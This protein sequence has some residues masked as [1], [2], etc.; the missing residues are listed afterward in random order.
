[1]QNHHMVMIIEDNSRVRAEYRDLL[2]G[3]GFSVVEACDGAEGLIWLLGETAD[4]IV[5]DL[6]VPVVDGRSFLEYRLRDVKISDIPVVV[7]S[8]RPDDAGLSRTLLRLGADR[9]LHQP[10]SREDFLGTVRGLLAKSRTPVVPP[11]AKVWPGARKDVRLAFNIPIRMRACSS[12]DTW[13]TLQD[14]SAGGVGAYVPRRLHEWESI[15]IT[16]PLEG[17]SLALKG[18]VQWFTESRTMMS[19]RYGIQFTERQSDSFPLHAYLFFREHAAASRFNAWSRLR[20]LGRRA[21]SAKV[22]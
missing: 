10:F 1:M 18:Y 12:G 19:Y 14:L 5:L 8:S 3:E 2:E 22:R 11:V 17:R 16:V 9:L 4:V 20:E 6:D 7:V 21:F 15:T 13:G